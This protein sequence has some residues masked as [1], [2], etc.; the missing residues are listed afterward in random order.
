[1]SSNSEAD[2]ITIPLFFVMEP[3]VGLISIAKDAGLPS[4]YWKHTA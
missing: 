2:L 1:M 3:W 4:I